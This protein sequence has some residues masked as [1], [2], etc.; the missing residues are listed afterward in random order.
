MVED[1]L[2]FNVPVTAGHDLVGTKVIRC[3][4]G[5]VLAVVAD[6]LTVFKKDDV[7]FGFCLLAA[8]VEGLETVAERREIQEVLHLLFHEKEEQ[9]QVEVREARGN[10]GAVLADWPTLAGRQ[11]TIVVFG[12]TDTVQSLVSR[13]G[14]PRLLAVAVGHGEPSP[15]QGLLQLDLSRQPEQQLE[16]VRALLL[17][18]LMA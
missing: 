15:R 11:Q 3:L 1:C 10:L 18:G 9:G 8:A 6:L 5:L 13:R 14:G 16:A 17:E 12:R 2:E 4:M 7:T